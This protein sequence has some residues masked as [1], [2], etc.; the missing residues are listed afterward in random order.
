M[1]CA[2][3]LPERSQERWAGSLGVTLRRQTRLR[4]D[5]GRDRGR[6]SDLAQYRRMFPLHCAGRHIVA[7]HP[8]IAA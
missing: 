7:L 3:L 5:R 8:Q 6:Q 4:H 1:S 2:P